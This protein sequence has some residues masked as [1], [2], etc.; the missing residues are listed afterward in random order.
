MM[1]TGADT[2]WSRG[3]GTLVSRSHRLDELWISCATEIDNKGHHRSE[4]DF[5][6]SADLEP[7]VTVILTSL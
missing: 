5:I 1:D 6:S 4:A 2:K 3:T 7:L